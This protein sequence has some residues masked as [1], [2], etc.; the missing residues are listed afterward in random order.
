MKLSW[1][2]KRA[3]KVS[4]VLKASIFKAI[5]KRKVE[6]E[7]VA[8]QQK[9]EAEAVAARQK[10]E[11]EAVV[12]QQK[13]E[14]EAVTAQQKAEAEAVAA[15]Q[16]VEAEAAVAQQKAEA[17]VVAARQKAE[18]EALEAQLISVAQQAEQVGEV[19]TPMPGSTELKLEDG[20]ISEVGRLRG[21]YRRMTELAA[22][23]ALKLEEFV[24]WL[25]PIQRYP[26]AS[27]RFMRTQCNMAV[28]SIS[29]IV[30]CR[31][32]RDP[33]VQWND[34]RFLTPLPRDLPDFF[35]EIRRLREQRLR[36]QPR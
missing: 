19:T 5:A 6:A 8:A 27:L 23:L 35:T 4:L 7:A 24:P 3:T 12:A 30:E 28:N 17:E 25:G 11:A 20:E 16:K 21:Y 22:C 34:P 29:E 18:L 2:W 26:T 15:R 32:N 36:E 14:A 13:A 1:S 10:A 9:A 33:N 31:Q